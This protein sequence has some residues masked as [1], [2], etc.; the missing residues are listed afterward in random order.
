MFTIKIVRI[1]PMKAFVSG[2]KVT[3]KRLLLLSNFP[4]AGSDGFFLLTSPHTTTFTLSSIFTPL[5]MIKIEIWETTLSWHAKFSLPV[6]VRASKTSVLKL[7]N[8]YK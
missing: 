5:E 1:F 2:K 6:A 8:I 4:G 7:P 3:S